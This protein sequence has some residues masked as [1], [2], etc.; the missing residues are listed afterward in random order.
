MQRQTITVMIESFELY[1][2]P[3][4]ENR[5]V[6]IYLPND[7]NESS[8]RYPVLYMFDGHNL[9]DDEEAAYGKS[10]G[11]REYLE[12]SGRKLI[13]V[14][15]YCSMHGIDRLIEYSPYAYR[16][17]MTGYVRGTG[18]D[19][20]DWFSGELKTYIDEHYRTWW[21]REATAIGGSSMGGIM[22]YYAVMK[23]NHIYSKAA[24]IS[25]AFRLSSGM[26]KAEV[27]KNELFPD[28][29]VFF[30]WGT[31]EDRQGRLAAIVH[32]LDDNLQ[33]KGISTYMYKH[34]R[35]DHSEASCDQEIPLWMVYLW[36]S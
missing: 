17:R 28:T 29:R 3:A 31:K 15:V 25:P 26:V 20:M 27:D 35:G 11:L 34:M 10:W 18:K 14:G 22:S 12:A 32:E 30:S 21:H 16:T 36:D 6:N 23:Y 19:T 13:V 1:Y 24:C 9:F 4:H 7:Y 2:A 33:A 5:R 8:E